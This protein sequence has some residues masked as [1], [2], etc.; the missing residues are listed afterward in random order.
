MLEPIL[1]TLS[2]AL[3]IRAAIY[4]S[5]HYL[6]VFREFILE[7]ISEVQIFV[8]LGSILGTLAT[9]QR[10]AVQLFSATLRHCVQVSML[11]EVYLFSDEVEILE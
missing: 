1:R 5:F 3:G 10:G 2:L 7:L 6:I 8:V 9:F 11:V 4:A